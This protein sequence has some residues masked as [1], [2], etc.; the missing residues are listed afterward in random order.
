LSIWVRS[1]RN[2]FRKSIKDAKT[3]WLAIHT[4]EF[5][6]SSDDMTLITI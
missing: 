1:Q 2:P 3:G 6:I 4:T 5:N